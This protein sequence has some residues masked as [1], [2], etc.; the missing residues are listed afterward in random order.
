MFIFDSNFIEIVFSKV[1]L[2]LDKYNTLRYYGNE[3]IRMFVNMLILFIQR[4]EYH[5]ATDIL[6]QIEN[7]KLNDDCLYER[8]CISFFAGILGIIEGKPGAE[9][10]C[11]DV[12]QIFQ[13]LNCKTSHKM[14]T[15]YLQTIKK[16]T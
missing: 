9:Q 15:A 12:L 11:D 13:L 10:K 6:N 16:K 2:N 8:C 5:K 3:S 7:Y 1:I 4:Q 14:F